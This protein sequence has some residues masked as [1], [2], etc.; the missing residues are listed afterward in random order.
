[1]TEKTK[2]TRDS[3]WGRWSIIQEARIPDH[4]IRGGVKVTVSPA[5]TKAVA[6][7]LSQWDI[8]GRQVYKSVEWISHST[9]IPIDSVKKSLRVLR[10]HGLLRRVSRG[11][12]QSKISILD[13]DELEKLRKPF[14]EKPVGDDVT[15]EE[16]EIDE[17][18][19]SPTTTTPKENNYY[20]S[21]T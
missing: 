1:M 13:W 15:L 6:L 18:T 5:A 20:A 3:M 19:T 16:I 10:D 21:R 7:E 9:Q 4:Y 2:P 17:P 11:P 14:R 8:P 12:S